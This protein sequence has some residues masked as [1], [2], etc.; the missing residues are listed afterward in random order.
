MP[1]ISQLPDAANANRTDQIPATQAGTT[2]RVTVAEVF[3]TFTL[4]DIP[5]G[6]AANGEVLKWNGTAW[7]PAADATGGGSLTWG[8]ITGT[9]SAQTDLQTALDARQPLDSTLTAFA[10]LTSGIPAVTSASTVAQRTITAGAGIAVTNG[11]GVS[12]NPTIAIAA[13]VAA[14]AAIRPTVTISTNTTLTAAAHAGRRLLCTA[15]VTLTVNAS[16]DFAS[17]GDDCEIVAFGG[18]VTISTTGATVNVETGLVGVI[19]R[20]GAAVLIKDQ[21]ADTYALFGALG[22]V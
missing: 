9:L 21:A 22:T 6:G 1:R 12:G 16:T 19:R 20:Y 8:G 14:Q 5:G 7:A 11:N 10:A 18:D 2:R 17:F 4:A 3:G 15:A 13:P